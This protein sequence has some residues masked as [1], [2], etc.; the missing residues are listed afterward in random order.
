[1]DVAKV[2]VLFLA[3][4]V[5]ALSLRGAAPAR[6]FDSFSA[7]EK[8]IE[9]IGT[10]L[11]SINPQEDVVLVKDLSS[12]KTNAQRLGSTMLGSFVL[13]SIQ[14]DF[15]ELQGP[16]RNIRLFRYG[17]SPAAKVQQKI[18]EKA[19]PSIK[20][21]YKED[22]FE[23]EDG[24]IKMS[25]DYRKK[26]LEKDLPKVL[27]QAGAE[28]KMDANGNIVGFALFEVEKDSIYAKAGLM[29]GDVIKSIN[30]EELNSAAGAVKTLNS[31][32][33]ANDFQVVIDR[34]GT[35]IPLSLDVK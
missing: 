34:G 24:V 11:N 1:M 6:P 27:M 19:P 30:G 26:L 8:G 16:Q 13:I 17:F 25:E 29:D 7:S 10:I 4:V 5:Q 35:T 28:A 23:R 31:L 12:N 32:K 9:I 15:I 21:T 22:G 3:I 2:L 18:V 14:G 20:G 33:G